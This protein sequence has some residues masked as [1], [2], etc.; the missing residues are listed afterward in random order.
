MTL[1]V[2]LGGT[3]HCLDIVLE[4]VGLSDFEVH[5]SS[6]G[7]FVLARSPQQGATNDCAADN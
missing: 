4:Y 1:F 2:I 3:F 5:V 6:Y 7:R